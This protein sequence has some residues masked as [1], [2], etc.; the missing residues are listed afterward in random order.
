M[1]GNTEYINALERVKRIFAKIKSE[2]NF[3]EGEYKGYHYRIV[4]TETMGILCGYVGIPKGHRY[5]KKKNY[6]DIDID[7]HGGLTFSDWHYLPDP[8][9]LWWIGFDCGHAWD[10]VPFMFETEMRLYGTGT[11][12]SNEFHALLSTTTYKDFG[13]VQAECYNIIKQLKRND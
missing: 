11:L 7:C 4:R 13:F 8:E 1:N 9:H 5:Y 3:F 2:P 12:T 6:D 10:F